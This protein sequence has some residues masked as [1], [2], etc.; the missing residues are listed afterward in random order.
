MVIDEKKAVEKSKADIL[1]AVAQLL[2]ELDQF[3]LEAEAQGDPCHQMLKN[4]RAEVTRKCAVIQKH[5]E[6]LK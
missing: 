4:I 6:S 1:N 2:E 3:V 5:T